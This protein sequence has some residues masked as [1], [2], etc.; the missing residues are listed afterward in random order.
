MLKEFDIVII[1][2]GPAGMS[3]AIYATKPNNKVA[4]IERNAP[5]GK[6]LE[7]DHISNFP[8]KTNID[9]IS[10]SMEMFEHVSTLP[11]EYISDNVIDIKVENNIKTVITNKGQYNAKVVIIATGT[12]EK[13]IG[14]KGETEYYNKGVSYCATCDAPLYKDK[15]VVVIGD[16]DH[17]KEEAN[18]LKGF[19]SKVIEIK[20]YS[21]IEEILGDGDRV[22]SIKCKDKIVDTDGVFPFIGVEPSS[23]FAKRLNIVDEKGNIVVNSKME[24]SIE[25]IYAVGDVIVKDLRQI[26]TACSDG[27]IA[28]NNALKYLYKLNQ[29]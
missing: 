2:C 8:N 10:L 3:A 19:A 7:T 23:M 20:N 22:T 12:K 6:M 25:G 13:R 17:A 11:C 4:I 21:D 9:G 27:A 26:V 18:Y 28:G 29:K 15:T 24:T 1:G 16:N 5:G 14:I